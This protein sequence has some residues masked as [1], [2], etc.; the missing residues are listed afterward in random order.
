MQK[1][2]LHPHNIN[3]DAASVPLLSILLYAIQSDF[4][5]FFELHYVWIGAIVNWRDNTHIG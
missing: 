4:I 3:V 5:Y 1:V 2:I